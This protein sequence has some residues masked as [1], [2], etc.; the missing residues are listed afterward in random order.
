M[1]SINSKRKSDKSDKSA[2]KKNKPSLTNSSSMQSSKGGEGVYGVDQYQEENE[3]E[4]AL[5]M[6]I[7]RNT[8][9]VY[10]YKMIK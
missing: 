6:R 1:S 3:M 8:K 5:L 2:S 9:I 7:I 10:F 4:R